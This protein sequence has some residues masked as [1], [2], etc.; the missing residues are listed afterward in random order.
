[1]AE[2]QLKRTVFISHSTYDGYLHQALY[3]LLVGGFGLGKDEIFSSSIARNLHT[4]KD[5]IEAIRSNICNCEVVLLLMTSS[6]MRSPFCQAELG[7][8]WGLGK[9]I[10]PIVVDPVSLADYNRTPLQGRQFRHLSDMRVI[11]DEFCAAGWVKTAD[12]ETF[13]KYHSQF[14]ETIRFAQK[15]GDAFVATIVRDRAKMPCKSNLQG[16]RCLQLSALVPLATPPVPGETH[17][18][19]YN[20][21]RFEPVA[22]G[23]MVQFHVLST[24]LHDNPWDDGLDNTR[25]IYPSTLKRI[26]R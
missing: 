3:D 22:E 4:N 25:N 21:D 7:A 9:P 20:A 8:A 11:Y 18:L 6:Y 24:Q 2:S 14:L 16:K 17:W 12:S 23:D 19:F 13:S 10:V 1:M 15:D 26:N 5:F